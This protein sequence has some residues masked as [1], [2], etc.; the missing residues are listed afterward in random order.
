MTFTCVWDHE[1]LTHEDWDC[2]LCVIAEERDIEFKRADAAEDELQKVKDKLDEVNGVSILEVL[3]E[4]DEALARLNRAEHLLKWTVSSAF[5]FVRN[6]PSETKA[7]M[8]EVVL[9]AERELNR[10]LYPERAA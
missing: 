5:S 9:S 2:P 1:P 10:F 3:A 6:R 8:R 4:R 7:R